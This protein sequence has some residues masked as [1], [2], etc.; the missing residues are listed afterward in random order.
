MEYIG[1]YSAQNLDGGGS[2][3]MVINNKNTL[4]NVLNSNDPSAS[5][6]CQWL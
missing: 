1:C 2:T 6:V 5:G 4:G 3:T